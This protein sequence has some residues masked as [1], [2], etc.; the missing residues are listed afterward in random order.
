LNETTGS[1]YRN[2]PS[3]GRGRQLGGDSLFDVRDTSD[4]KFE[5]IARWAV[6]EA[7]I[8][9]KPE[10]KRTLLGYKGLQVNRRARFCPLLKLDLYQL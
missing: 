9:A 7:F 4:V 2:Y 6:L 10:T 1:R 5:R 3:V 8:G